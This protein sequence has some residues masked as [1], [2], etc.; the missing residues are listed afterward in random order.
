MWRE[1]LYGSRN[2]LH[3]TMSGGSVRPGVNNPVPGGLPAYQEFF[4]SS[5]NPVVTSPIPHVN[6]L[7]IRIVW[8]ISIEKPPE[9]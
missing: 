8:Q 3:G 6:Q 4:S 1:G 9:R 2:G 7:I 5:L